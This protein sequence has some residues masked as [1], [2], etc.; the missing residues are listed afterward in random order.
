MAPSCT[1]YLAS[2]LWNFKNYALFFQ[3]QKQ[4]SFI[5]SCRKYVAVQNFHQPTAQLP[6][7]LY[8]AQLLFVQSKTV[9]SF[10]AP[11]FYSFQSSRLFFNHHISLIINLATIHSLFDESIFDSD[12]SQVPFYPSCSIIQLFQ[13]Q[14]CPK[15]A[16]I[17]LC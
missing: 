13:T 1:R 8:R 3:R 9:I 5:S 6:Q 17:N 4:S 2:V 15:L 10:V 16:K 12:V 7:H 14:P 11:N